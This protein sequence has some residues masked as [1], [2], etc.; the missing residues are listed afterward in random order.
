MKLV[1]VE[2]LTLEPQGIVSGGVITITSVPSAK[3]KA[4]GKGAYAGQLGFSVSGANASGY[5]P[6]TVMTAGPAVIPASASKC[7]AGVLPLLLE[8]DQSAAVAMTGTISGTPTPF[9]EPWKV[10]AAGQSKVKAV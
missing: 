2:G 3:M 4:G 10:T 1:A 5:D 9:V 6:G 8:G 7:R